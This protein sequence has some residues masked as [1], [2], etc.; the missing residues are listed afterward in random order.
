M[1]S[2]AEESSGSGK[3]HCALCLHDRESLENT[4]VNWQSETE[5]AERW[6]E[7][8]DREEIL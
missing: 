3:H 6:Q 2:L 4:Q 5:M 8:S 1:E 7:R